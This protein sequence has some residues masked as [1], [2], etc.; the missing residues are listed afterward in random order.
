[1]GAT[2]AALPG[3]VFRVV[4]RRMGV[5]NTSTAM[6]GEKSHFAPNFRTVIRVVI[7]KTRRKLDSFPTFLLLRISPRMLL[8]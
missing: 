8:G 3:F 1:M 7:L 2:V 6:V 4:P 5:R